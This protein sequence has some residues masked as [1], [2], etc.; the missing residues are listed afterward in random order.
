LFG[1][2]RRWVGALVG[3]L[4]LFEMASVGPNSRYANALR[5][6]G[7]D[8]RATAFY[9]AHVVADAVH[10]DVARREL[11]GALIADEPQRAGDVVFGARALSTAEAAF[12]SHLLSSWRAGSSSLHR[13]DDPAAA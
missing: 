7:F 3:H 9:D 13:A 10:E 11:V 2:H 1:L 5:R 8:E 4:A 12:T 6:L